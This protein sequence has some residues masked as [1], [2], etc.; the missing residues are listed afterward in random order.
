MEQYK[1]DFINLM[2]EADVLKFGDFVTKS[3]RNTPF[4]INLGNINQGK[5]LKALGNMYAECIKHHFSD[6]NV[7]FGPAYKGIS[8]AVAT[9][10]SLNEKY[11][12]NISFSAN[13]KEAKDH[14]DKGIFFGKTI[15]KGDNVVIIEDVTT[16]GTSIKETFPLLKFSN[17]LGLIVAVD[18]MEVAD[19][20]ITALKNIEEKYGIKTFSIVT[21]EEIISYLHN[22]EVNGKIYIT[23]EIKEEINEYYKLYG[24]KK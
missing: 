19:G 10:I 20:N 18:R 16:A 14:G 11:D 3:G 13:R 5:Y 23:D 12:M 7:L 15:K 1:I 2:L 6:F 9:A 17:V 24:A 4:F 8:L 21:I 22:K